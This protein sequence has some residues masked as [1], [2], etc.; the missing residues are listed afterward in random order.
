V[1]NSIRTRAAALAA[2]LALAATL[3]ASAALAA[4]ARAAVPSNFW[5]AVPQNALTAA[6]LERLR[7]GGV[8]SLRTLVNWTGMQKTPR[9]EIEWGDVDG[10]VE[11]FAKA[12][13]EVLPFL[14]GAP[15]WAVREVAVPGT[16]GGAKAPARLPVDGRAGSGWS[17]FVREAVERYGPRG[18]FWS[19]HPEVP[20]DPIHTWQIWNEPNFKYFAARPNPGEYGR[21]VRRSAQA[22]HSVD[23]GA[24]VLLAGL[25]ARPGEAGRYHPPRAYTAVEFLELMFKR[26]PGIAASFD[27]V[28]LHPYTT[29]Y[30]TIPAE[31]EEVRALLRARGAA[32]KG[33]WVTELGWS[34]E[35]PSHGDAF[36]KGVR[37]QATQLSGAFRLLRNNAARWRLRQVFW[38]SVDDLPNACNF[39]GGSG[40][41]RKGF[42]PRPAW[43]DYVQFAGGRAS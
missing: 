42:K 6:Q 14:Y 26:V 30:L 10:T 7:R 23:L 3:L 24:T 43:R 40:L 18:V 19:E 8:D 9:S 2:L 31:I 39:C 33:L 12:H 11:A 1:T 17:K 35:P 34:A 36:A 13:I 38:F 16:G 15:R 25:F 21:L 5:G 32:N 28:A 41:F 27:G 20:R 22:I 37:G 29:S 4:P